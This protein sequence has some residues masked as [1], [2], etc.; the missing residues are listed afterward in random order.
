LRYG[1]R[2][3]VLTLH[4]LNLR[5][6]AGQTHAICSTSGAGKTSIFNLI[7]GFYSPCGGAITFGDHS[8]KN[9]P[10][11]I[12]RRNMA[13]VSQDATLFQGTINWNILLGAIKPDDHSYE[14][15]VKVCRDAW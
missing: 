3:N 1:T 2:A 5:I 14:Q 7:Q 15:I 13:Y 9:I 11:V 6:T 10:L 8:I 12:L 4:N